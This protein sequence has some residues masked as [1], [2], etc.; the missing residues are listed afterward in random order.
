MRIVYSA[1]KIE[2]RKAITA[3]AGF[4]DGWQDFKLSS[5]I[6]DRDTGGVMDRDRRCPKCQ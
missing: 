2:R 1:E 5:L 4:H 6:I 3:C